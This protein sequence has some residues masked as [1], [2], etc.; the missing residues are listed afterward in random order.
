MKRKY[1]CLLCGNENLEILYSET[2]RI[3]VC[4]NECCGHIWT[5]KLEDD[6]KEQR[7]EII[8]MDIAK[9]KDCTCIIHPNGTKEYR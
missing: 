7:H 4:K 2:E 5:E 1:I 3:L 9:Q 6:M 8:G